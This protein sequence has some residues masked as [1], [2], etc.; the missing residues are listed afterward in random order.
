MD[1]EDLLR[2]KR[3][4][5]TL[6]NENEHPSSRLKVGRLGTDKDSRKN[7]VKQ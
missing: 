1:N 7:I 3:R 4:E 2:I 5:W 6:E